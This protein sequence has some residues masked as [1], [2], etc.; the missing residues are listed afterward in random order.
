MK[1]EVEITV[2]ERN[3]EMRGYTVVLGMLAHS[4]RTLSQGQMEHWL[5]EELWRGRLVGGSSA[6][7]DG[8]AIS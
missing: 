2:N 5:G 3:M 7:S 8:L 4:L 1:L 6:G